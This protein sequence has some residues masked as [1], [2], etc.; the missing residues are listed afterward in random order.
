MANLESMKCPICFHTLKFLFE[1][2][3]EL[4]T[5]KNGKEYWKHGY[6]AKARYCKK[7]Y[8]D[9]VYPLDLQQNVDDLTNL[10]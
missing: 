5:S 1:R 4:V 6:E 8:C 9:I 3:S 2:T 7:K 10:I